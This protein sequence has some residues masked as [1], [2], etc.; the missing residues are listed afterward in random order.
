MS[1]PELTGV[2]ETALYV[3]DVDR[4]HDF[5]ADVFGFKTLFHNERGAAMS[6]SDSYVLLLFRKGGSLQ[7]IVDEN[8]T[9]PP[10]DG[11]GSLHFAFSIPEH[12]KARVTGACIAMTSQRARRARMSA[13]FHHCWASSAA[14]RPPR[15]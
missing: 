8:G 7:P 14:S 13:C 15:P 5:Y 1:V 6:V 2:L 12:R 11:D 3:D 9:I 10:H 4:A